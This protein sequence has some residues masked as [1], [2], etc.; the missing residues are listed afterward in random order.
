[1]G[2]LGVLGDAN[3]L[4]LN[5][6]GIVFGLNSSLDIRGSF[7]A[8]TA[9]RFTLGDG[10]DFSAV[11]PNEAPMLEVSVPIGLQYGV[12]R[13]G[14]II[15]AGDLAVAPGENLTLIG[16]T[17]INTGTLTAPGGEV[18]LASISDS[19]PDPLSSAVPGTTN[20][21]LSDQGQITDSTRAIATA[22]DLTLNT[23][24]LTVESGSEL[25]VRSLL[26]RAGNLTV[27]T[28]ARRLI[29]EI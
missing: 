7:V 20:I 14:A 3:L 27:T 19:L 23:R 2:Q 11:N 4:L 8:T 18:S 17:V 10:D 26:G 5:P 24:Q 28:N 15:N 22:G 9:D 1:M 12:G 25:T 29:V 21:Q 6:N 13:S 16:E